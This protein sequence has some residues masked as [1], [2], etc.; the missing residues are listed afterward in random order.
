MTRGTGKLRDGSN[1]RLSDKSSDS[2]S[3]NSPASPST[4]RSILSVLLSPLA[5]GSSKLRST[6]SGADDGGD[7]SVVP[8]RLNLP[9]HQLW[10]PQ[11]NPSNVV[12][13]MQEAGRADAAPVVVMALMAEREVRRTLAERTAWD[14]R[15]KRAVMRMAAVARVC[16]IRFEA[17]DLSDIAGE[18]DGSRK[19][20][21]N[22]APSSRSLP[23]G[24][25]RKTSEKSPPSQAL[26]WEAKAEAV[27]RFCRHINA[28]LLL[29]PSSHACKALNFS[30]KFASNN[31]TIRCARD[32]P[33]PLIKLGADI[34]GDRKDGRT[35]SCIG[36]GSVI[37]YVAD[38]P[39]RF[40]LDA[41]AAPLARHPR[42]APAV[43][44][45]EEVTQEAME[46][47]DLSEG[48]T[49]TVVSQAN[50]HITSRI[51]AETDSG[52]SADIS[53]GKLSSEPSAVSIAFT[54][55]R[56]RCVVLLPEN[57]YSRLI[58]ITHEW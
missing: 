27:I 9:R 22:P 48:R 42:V 20:D 1:D 7:D 10:R 52:G 21:I 51:G 11:L 45:M 50:T 39:R 47:V 31:F 3:E 30:G 44:S 13:Q 8:P 57:V 23:S 6:A 29:L 43:D 54:S 40:W 19:R 14:R 34:G 33:C 55:A 17:I 53:A 46:A 58:L 35:R 41:A 32:A 36:H 24:S 12:R 5:A 25:P 18:A 15:T 26:S 4:P 2:Q 16:K 38:I 37:C 49:A 56:H 28:E